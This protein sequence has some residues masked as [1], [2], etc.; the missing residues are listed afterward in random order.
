M[1]MPRPTKRTGR[2]FVHT[3][4]VPRD[5]VSVF[6][7]L[8]KEATERTDLSDEAPSPLIA[9]NPAAIQPTKS[10]NMRIST[11]LLFL[12]YA[13]IIANL[14]FMRPVLIY[15]FKHKFYIDSG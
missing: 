8:E 15:R 13:R 14:P 7:E 5:A 1:A 9:V 10:I 4:V 12:G 2:S 3:T 11:I 6:A